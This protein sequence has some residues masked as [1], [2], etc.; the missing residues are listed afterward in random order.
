M[1][2]LIIIAVGFGAA[3]ARAD[4]LVYSY[5]WARANDSA[6]V[7]H[8]FVTDVVQI[9]NSQQDQFKASVSREIDGSRFAQ[10]DVE[11]KSSADDLELQQRHQKERE[12]QQFTF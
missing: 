7:T 2:L 8:E 11:C 4:N 12:R 9:L 5:C 1:P 3:Q 6:N 10:V